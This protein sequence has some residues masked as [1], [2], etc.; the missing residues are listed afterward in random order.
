MTYALNV[1]LPGSL[2]DRLKLSGVANQLV[3]FFKDKE[4]RISLD[5]D[6]T[7]ATASPSLKLNT[8]AQEDMAKQALEKEKQKLLDQGKKKVEDELKKKAEEGLKK[9]FKKP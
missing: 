1:K 7:G 3:Q 6:V 9:L 4:G 8:K 5:F 2:S